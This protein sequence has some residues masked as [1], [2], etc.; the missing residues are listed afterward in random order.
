MAILQFSRKQKL[1]LDLLD[2]PQV[3][4]L[5]FGGGAGGGKTMLVCIWIVMQCI[6]YPGIRI[7]LGRKELTRLKQ[8]TLVT[9]LSKVHPIMEVLRSDFVYQD[10]KGLLTYRNGSALQLID[11][12]RQP[13]D[14]DF[15]TFGS[16]ELTHTVI[17]EAG[18]IVKKAKDVFSSRKNRHLNKEYGIV[19][20][21]VLTGNPSQNFT[22]Q[23]YYEPYKN[24]GMGDYQKWEFGKVE[25]ADLELEAFRV[26][27][28][29]LPTDNPLVDKNYIEVLK[30]L[31]TQERKRLYEGNWD[32]LDT[33]DMLFTGQLIDRALTSELTE[34]K[35]YIGVDVADKGKDKT[36]VSLIENGILIEQK[37]LNVDTTRERAI[38]ELYALELIKFAQQKGFTSANA[39]QIAIESNGVGV[40]MRDFMR[41]KG[42]A[43]TEYTA[44]SSTRSNAFYNGAKHLDDGKLKIYSQLE[45]LSELRKQLMTIT[46]E[47]KENLEPKILEKKKIK[48]VLGYSP[49]EADSFIIADW[50]ANQKT[51]AT[52]IIF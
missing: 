32:Y 9:L 8:T 15:D 22:Y 45:T 52:N 12:A 33:D 19:G 35:K 29:S 5:Y 28:K 42:W 3:I 16:L 31:P 37:R 51:K 18:E 44:T 23:E 27:I 13:S 50:V 48:E 40:G 47:F 38:S 10:Q 1:A 34:G 4:E 6:K 26:F 11:M 21:T 20:K 41:S 2:N 46:Y 30:N 43:I 49:D 17:E 36:I 14:P 39:R 7:G 25:I 24:L